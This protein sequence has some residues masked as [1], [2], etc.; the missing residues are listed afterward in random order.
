MVIAWLF[1]VFFYGMG[2]LLLAAVIDGKWV[3]GVERVW[4][5][6]LSIL[7][8]FIGY[9]LM[10]LAIG[11][12]K[13]CRFND[14]VGIYK[15]KKLN[16]RRQHKDN[17][18]PFSYDPTWLVELAEKQISQKTDIINSL[19]LCTT[20][21]GFCNCGCGRLYF[22]DPISDDWDF[23]QVIKLTG[24]NTPWWIENEIVLTIMKDQRIGAIKTPT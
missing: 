6:L 20:V 22:V 17:V 9:F 3:E 5:G 4:L 23:H 10:M 1:C 16:M 7:F 15:K 11:F 19:R 12:S 18:A 21:I 13:E 14:P 24:E 8:L 2:I